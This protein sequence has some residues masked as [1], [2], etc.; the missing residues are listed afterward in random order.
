MG[1]HASEQLKRV[2]VSGRPHVDGVARP[3]AKR[4]RVFLIGWRPSSRLRREV[5]TARTTVLF[6]CLAAI[7]LVA[8]V[9]VYVENS[10]SQVAPGAHIICELTAGGATWIWIPVF[11]LNSPF[12]GLANATMTEENQTAATSAVNG[13]VLANFRLDRVETILLSNVSQS[14]NGRSSPCG[15]S[16]RE[17]D[18]YSSN[19]SVQIGLQSAGSQDDT[20]GP[21]SLN[22]TDPSN[23]SV[24]S[25]AT[26]DD[27]YLQP[28][29]GTVNGC[30]SPPS[31]LE[32]N[33]TEENFTL[34]SQST[35]RG[36][37]G[38]LTV[39]DNVTYLYSFQGTVGSWNVDQLTSGADSFDYLPCS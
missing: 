34:P 3:R 8:A 16:V 36:L 9:V 14:G 6:A 38:A 26:V 28:S 27:R 15:Q 10:T 31:P 39:A 32:R 5:G 30:V 23:G 19:V 1:E 33:V 24:F 2:G 22:I 17:V 35:S 18:A 25:S 11:I 20:Y 4:E 29:G 12:G 13:S 21:T 7:V 37:T